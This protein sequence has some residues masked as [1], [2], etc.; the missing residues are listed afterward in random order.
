M[1]EMTTGRIPVQDLEDT[2]VD[3]GHRVEDALAPRVA[4]G[5]TQGKDRGGIQEVREFS[6]DLLQYGQHPVNHEAAPL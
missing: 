4:Q 2:E 3:G 1:R 5:T 6:L